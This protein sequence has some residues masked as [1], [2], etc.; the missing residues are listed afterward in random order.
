M[1]VGS[2]QPHDGQAY[3]DLTVAPL[4]VR[5]QLSGSFVE[6][7]DGRGDGA[8]DVRDALGRV[9]VQVA[10]DDDAVVVGLVALAE[11]EVVARRAVPDVSHVGDR[12]NGQANLNAAARSLRNHP[13]AAA[14]RWPDVRSNR[15]SLGS[16]TVR[17]QNTL[18]V[19]AN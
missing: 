5:G 2:S 7:L 4:E 18:I 12:P 15:P 19:T 14:I 8:V 17:R 10:E 16:W 9:A 13:L 3:W 11:G 1:T 6:G